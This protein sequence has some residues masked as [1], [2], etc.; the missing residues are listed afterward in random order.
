MTSL[1]KSFSSLLLLLVVC[2][3]APSFADQPTKFPVYQNA[4]ADIEVGYS[5]DTGSTLFGGTI[6]LDNGCLMR[7]VDYK[8]RDDNVMKTWSAGDALVFR[9]QVIDD[10]LIL[11]A[12]RIYRAKEE[13]VEPYLI[14]DVINSSEFTLKIAEVNDDGKFVRLSD[15]SVWE[16]SWINHFSTKHWKAGER[17]LVNGQGEHNVY[18][19]INLDA[20]VSKNVHCAVANLI[21]Q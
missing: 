18:T 15:N 20:P 1:K 16:F 10:A 3:A 19:F 13:T 17:V 12:K 11:S 8:T 21:T 5:E 2:Q 9:S 7:I 4:I 6:K 14:Y